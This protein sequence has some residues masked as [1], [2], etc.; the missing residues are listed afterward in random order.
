MSSYTNSI[1]KRRIVSTTYT[2]KLSILVTYLRYNLRQNYTDIY[3]L[4]IKITFSTFFYY[5]NYFFNINFDRF[6]CTE[7]KNS[8]YLSHTNSGDFSSN[9]TTC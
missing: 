7:L 2:P 5:Q 8:H 6:E 3:F 1:T 9:I 4:I